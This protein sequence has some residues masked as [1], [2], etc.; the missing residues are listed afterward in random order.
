[1]EDAIKIFNV[2][3]PNGIA[4]FIVDCSSAHEAYANNAL[5]THKMN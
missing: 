1:M 2:K 4:V 3:Y 5:I